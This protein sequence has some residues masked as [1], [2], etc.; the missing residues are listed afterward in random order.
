MKKNYF[1]FLSVLV[2]VCCF[3][4]TF[5][6]CSDDDNH[7]SGNTEIEFYINDVKQTTH[8]DILTIPLQYSDMPPIGAVLDVIVTFDEGNNLTNPYSARLS[9]RGV[10]L[11]NMK[12]GDDLVTTTNFSYLMYYKNETYSLE[13]EDTN[14]TSFKGYGGSVIIKEINLGNRTMKVEFSNI[15]IPIEK[16]FT[17]SNSKTVKVKGSVKDEILIHE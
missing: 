11:E 3:S 10:K 9:F 2:M 14:K 1:K 5:S 12:V 16:N 17:I 7:G 13:K 6:S 4:F 15:T 8:L